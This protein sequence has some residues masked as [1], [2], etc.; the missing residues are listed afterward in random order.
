MLY[1]YF[2]NMCIPHFEYVKTHCVKV[3]CYSLI[4]YKNGSL[5]CYG[6]IT[7]DFTS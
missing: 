1:S 4:V 5:L 2:F 7:H 3:Y 6:F